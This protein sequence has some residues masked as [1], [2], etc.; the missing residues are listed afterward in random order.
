MLVR[1][2]VREGM[3]DVLQSVAMEM[4]QRRAPLL[5]GETIG[6]RGELF[7]DSEL[8]ALFVSSPAYF[9]NGLALFRQPSKSV[10]VAWLVP[11]ASDEVAFV[12]RRG[13]EE[14]EDLL[15]SSNPD[16]L[17]PYRKSILTPAP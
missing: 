10:I 15:A 5:R 8:T 4:L 14:F 2:D 17:D 9:P 3:V 16:L 11:I 6:P 13:G 7:R 12:S 1:K